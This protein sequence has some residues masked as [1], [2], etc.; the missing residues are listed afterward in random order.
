[1]RPELAGDCGCCCAN[2]SPAHR[3]PPSLQT[4]GRPM[5]QRAYN[6]MDNRG[7]RPLWQAPLSGW[8]WHPLT[9]WSRSDLGAFERR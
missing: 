3:F 5:V 4:M 8:A 6:L 1:M 2:H 9:A 7:R